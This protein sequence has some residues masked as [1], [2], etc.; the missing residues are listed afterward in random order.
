MIEGN[1]ENI[2]TLDNFIQEYGA[3]DL[4][5]DA[6]HLKEVFFNPGMKHKIVVNGNIISDKYASELEENKRIITFNTKEYYKYRYNPKLLSYDI[7]GTTELWFFILM[8][9]ELYTAIEFNLHKLVLFDS[10]I[11]TK[12]NR[13]IELDSE[14]LEINSMEV[15]EETDEGV[16]I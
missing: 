3:E 11:I 6:F 12:L 15:K 1:S 2:Y 16:S 4:R 14:F 7:Y 13:M 5:V 10:A 8:A 9:N